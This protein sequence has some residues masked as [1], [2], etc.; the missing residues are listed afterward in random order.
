MSVDAISIDEDV[1]M[2]IDH[3]LLISNDDVANLRV[4]VSNLLSMMISDTG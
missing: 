4:E 2:M 3:T 1:E